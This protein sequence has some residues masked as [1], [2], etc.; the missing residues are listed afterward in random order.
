MA[1]I[2]Q[3]GVGPAPYGKPVVATTA[4]WIGAGISLA[5][6]VGVGVWGYKLL[7]RDV[8]GIPLIEASGLPMRV[9]P[10]EPGGEQA[11]HQGLAVNKVAGFGTAAPA[12]DRVV[13]APRRV[14]LAPEDQPVGQIVAPD[15]LVTE[16]EDVTLAALQHTALIDADKAEALQALADQIA[17]GSKPFEQVD[18]GESADVKI[19][20]GDAKVVKVEK[21]ATPSKVVA[22]EA[23]LGLVRSLR[24]QV[25]PSEL[26]TASLAPLEPQVE[27]AL[28]VAPDQVPAGTRLVQLGAFESAEVAKSEW[29]RLNGRFA[30]FMDGKQRVIQKATSGGRVFFR[31]RAM[32]FE[33]LSDARRFCATFVAAKADC[34][35]VTSK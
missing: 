28:D 12:A 15:P 23:G 13:L 24:P 9:A 1:D 11:E 3:A 27:V 31:L 2:P 8:K 26:R 20:V 17:A 29:D 14:T 18:L 16:G 6:I 4:N 35:P 30:E 5:L 7:S 34:I 21:S 19:T 33:D 25:R 32:G 22:P 10:V